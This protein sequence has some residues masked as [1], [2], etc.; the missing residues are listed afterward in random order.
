MV[1]AKH[2]PSGPLASLVKCFWYWETSAQAHSKERLMPN[3]EPTLVFELRDEAIRVYDWKDT[4]HFEMF[5]RAVLCGPRTQPFV[6][7]T[8]QQERVFGI[9]F[10]PGGS[11]PF[12]RDRGREFE[13]RHVALD[14]LWPHAANEIRERLLEAD[15]ASAMFRVAEAALLAQLTRPL[16][17]HPAV[18]HA[19]RSFSVL[20]HCTRVAAVIDSIGMSHR[21]FVQIFSDQI[22]MTPKAFC[23]VQR[24]QRVLQKVNVARQ[25]DW[26]RIALDC[27]YYDQAH[28]IHD[29][30]SFSGFTPTVYKAICGEHE[31]HVPLV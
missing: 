1:Q 10:H 12:F 28:F 6:I 31:N 2:I 26:P 18:A 15:S 3:G 27:G 29:F 23:R 5:G 17:L 11:F 30:Q 21:R 25:I 7:E 20:S 24:F 4:S 9:Q 16:A 8:A 19:A 13:N 14:L 22:G